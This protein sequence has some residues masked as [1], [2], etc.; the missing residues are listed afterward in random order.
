MLVVG[1]G[2]GRELA[3]QAAALRAWVKAGGRV[4]ALGLD[5][6]EANS[7]LPTAVTM[8]RGEHIAALFQPFRA[9]SLLAGVA[10]ADVHN[11]DP[12]TLP[13]VT[14]GAAAYGDGVLAVEGSTCL[15]P[16]SP[17]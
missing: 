3:V 8:E 14:G 1:P 9:K 11:R 15:L 5:Q 12:R 6:D 7:F 16:A 10:P 13:L 2:G 17:V 4:L